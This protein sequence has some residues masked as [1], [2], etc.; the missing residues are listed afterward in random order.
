MKI[1]M[2]RS[3]RDEDEEAEEEDEEAEEEDKVVD[4]SGWGWLRQ[5]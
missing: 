1:T 2:K 3:S 4:E 5:M